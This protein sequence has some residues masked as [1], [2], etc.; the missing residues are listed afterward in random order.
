[1][2]IDSSYV[3]MES[4]RSKASVTV[5]KIS[6]ATQG[7]VQIQQGTF[8]NL[9][10]GWATIPG[11]AS[12]D[13]DVMSGFR[14]SRSTNYSVKEVNNTG[15]METLNRIR[16]ECITYFLKLFFRDRKP[17]GTTEDGYV[18][19]APN[20]VISQDDLYHARADVNMPTEPSK[21]HIRYFHVEKEETVF[22]GMGRVV[23]A[24]GREISFNLEFSMTRSFAKYYEANYEMPQSELCD[25][26]VINLNTNMASLSDQ[27][28][29]FDLDRDGILDRISNLKKGSGYLAFDKNGDGKINDGGELFGTYTGSGFS[30]LAV[31]DDDK[32]GW[33]DEDDAIFDKLL[34]WM[35]DEDGKDV[36][37]HLKEAGVGAICLESVSTDFSLNDMETNET[38]GVI[39]RTG[40]FL[41]EDGRTGTVQHI[42]VAK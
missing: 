16:Q 30:E 42:D 13:T 21:F 11:Q 5:A 6:A 41:F 34:I 36:L 1:M 17:G 9:L 19:G 18:Y 3:G 12:D 32:D 7:S 24:D 28:F 8:G 25:P 31:H 37:Y 10:T 15:R 27:K 40:M 35:K 33:I 2:R 29:T 14:Y 20:S 22:T 38:N 4:A 39:R 26:L 23:S